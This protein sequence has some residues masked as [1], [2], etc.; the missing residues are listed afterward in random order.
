[1]KQKGDFRQVRETENRWSNSEDSHFRRNFQVP[2]PFVDGTLESACRFSQAAVEV[3]LSGRDTE[4]IQ[5]DFRS[6]VCPFFVR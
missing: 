3:M 1:M 4:E 5:A 6:F 2:I